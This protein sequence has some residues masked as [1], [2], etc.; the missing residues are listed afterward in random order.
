MRI[1]LTTVGSRGD[2]QPVV[3]LAD[4]LQKA[5][6]TCVLVAPPAFGAQHEGNAYARLAAAINLEFRSIGTGFE[7]LARDRLVARDPAGSVWARFRTFRVT[8]DQVLEETADATLAAC[9]GANLV[10]GSGLQFLGASVAERLGVPYAYLATTPLSLASAWYPPG[11]LAGFQMGKW[12]TRLAWRG[13]ELGLNAVLGPAL[14]R[15]RA[16]WGLAPVK[17]VQRHATYDATVL[18]AFSPRVC[19]PAPDWQPRHVPVGYWFLDEAWE[20][21]S[22]LTRFLDGGPAPLYVGFGSMTNRDPL[23]TA[24]LVLEAARA[25][26]TRV[27]LAGDWGGVGGEGARPD[28]PA[29]VLHGSAPQTWLFPRTS[30]VVHHGGAGTTAA[31]LRAGRPS[32]LVPHAGDQ[33]FWGRRLQALGV[34]PSPIPAHRLTAERLAAGMEAALREPSLVANATTLGQA[35]AAEDGLGQAVQLIEG[36][37]K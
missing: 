37:M 12:L 11:T 33:F 2:V 4:A 15:V 32:V 3:A 16:S 7:D 5:G 21:P 31:G 25:V 10:L 22:D 14:N 26:D 19:P 13:S 27:I 1:A 9:E 29:F 35:I 30:A 36:M 18:L 23:R 8:L 6:H 34:S 28:A 20:P 17:N 24:R